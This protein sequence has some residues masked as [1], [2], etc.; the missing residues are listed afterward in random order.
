[1]KIRCS[2]KKQVPLAELVPNPRNPN[3]HP[4]KQIEML[5]EILKFQ[6]FRQP[7]VVSNLSGFIVKGHGRLLAAEKAGFKKAPVDFQDYDSEAQE[8]A[9]LIADNK[10]AEL[11]EFD[12]ETLKD[13][14]G[15]LDT[16]E[17][18]LEMTGF[19]EEELENLVSQIHQESPDFETLAERFLAPPFSVL[20]S[21]QGAWQERKAWW[22]SL[23][24]KSEEGREENLLKFSDTILAGGKPPEAKANISKYDGGDLFNTDAF[25]GTSVFDPV[26]SEIAYLWFC[27]Q[28]GKVLDP[29]AGGSVRGIVA[30]RM[31]LP[32]L[33]VELREEQVKANEAQAKE[34]ETKKPPSWICGDSI[35]LNKLVGGKKF[36][37]IFSCPPYGD[38]ERYSKDER[39]LSNMKHEKFIASYE[40]IVKEALGKLKENRFA[41]FVVGDFR[42]KK[43]NLRNFIS[44]TT[45]AFEAGG[46]SLYNSCVFLTMLASLPLRVRRIFQGGR[47]LAPAHQNMLVFFKG[48]PG[49]IKA[50]FPEV[51]LPEAAE[52]AEEEENEETDP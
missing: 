43:G 50:E 34:I 18:D 3:S 11:S 22:L 49:S 45:A 51:P 35:N 46:A 27:P 10:I 13:L 14:I 29:F 5:A 25:S 47:K 28:G 12:A 24:I 9:D 6:G 15:E 16:G 30:G 17:L 32:Y 4:E 37:F 48:D 8:W 20:D 42:D 38:L 40:K 31:G 23:G 36:D 1:M 19:A 33:G 41:V 21:K 7:I 44:K 39:D 52:E 26:L 2:Y